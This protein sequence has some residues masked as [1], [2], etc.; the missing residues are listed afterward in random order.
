MIN[1]YATPSITNSFG[2]RTN[3]NATYVFNN[4]WTTEVFGNYNLGVKWQGQQP[5]MFSYTI[6]ARKQLFNSKG[7]IGIVIVNAFNQYINQKSLSIAKNLVTNSYRDVPYRSFGISFTYKFGK[8]KFTKP[9]ETENYLYAP[10][11]EN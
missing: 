3:I 2:F 7:S 11:P 10:P 5:N 8:L 6:A 9:K 4:Q 1:N